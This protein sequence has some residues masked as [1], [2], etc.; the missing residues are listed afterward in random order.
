MRIKW[1]ILLLSNDSAIP[2]NPHWFEDVPVLSA[3]SY[4]AVEISPLGI[5]WEHLQSD[6]KGKTMAFDDIYIVKEGGQ[7][8]YSLLQ[9]ISIAMQFHKKPVSIPESKSF[10]YFFLASTL[11]RL[12]NYAR[13]SILE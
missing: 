11:F 1:R 12:F 6:E 3:V 8:F 7:N 13:L 5:W 9:I 4:Q 10:S 2:C